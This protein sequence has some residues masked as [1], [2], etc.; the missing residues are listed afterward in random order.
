[1]D[2]PTLQ[3]WKGGCL[4]GR[5]PN[6]KPEPRQSTPKPPPE[7]KGNPRAIKEWKRIIAELQKKRF[8]ASSDAAIITCY[9]MAYATMLEAAEELSKSKLIVQNKAGNVFQHPALG[10]RNTAAKMC[11]RFAAE[12]GLTPSSRSRVRPEEIDGPGLE[13]PGD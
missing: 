12:L 1:M 5:P 2:R 13:M 7:V 3:R 9:V 6:P 4:T 11:A 8:C 10:I